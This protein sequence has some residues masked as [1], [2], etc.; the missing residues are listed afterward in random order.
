MPP[1][2]LLLCWW[3]LGLLGALSPA[4]AAAP[5]PP[6]VATVYVFLA[7]TCPISQS[8]TLTLRELHRQY[9]ARGVRFVGVFPDEQTRPAD[10]ILFRKTYQVPFEL[11]LDA[12]QQLTRRWGAR[13]TPEV[14]V[15]AADGR[16]VAYQGRIDN[17]YA[18]LGQRR[19]VVTTHELADA[20]AAV[21]AG[22]AVAQPRTEAVGCFINVKGLPAA[23]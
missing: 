14:V 16:T 18:A 23:N 12:G 19:T 15:V 17:A 6:T 3:A 2:L 10:V 22:K 9:A 7:E 21:V 8:C 1:R 4:R 20:L 5:A 11:K 13:I